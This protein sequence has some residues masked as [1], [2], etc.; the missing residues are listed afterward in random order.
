MP[1]GGC[2]HLSEAWQEIHSEKCHNPNSSWI[3]RVPHFLFDYDQPRCLE[4]ED[5][6]ESPRNDCYIKRS[7]WDLFGNL[8]QYLLDIFI[9]TERLKASFSG[10]DLQADSSPSD[11]NEDFWFP[12]PLSSLFL[13][14]AATAF[15]STCPRSGAFWGKRPSRAGVRASDSLWTLTPAWREARAGETWLVQTWARGTWASARPLLAL[16]VPVA[17]LSPAFLTL[18]SALPFCDPT[19]SSLP[20]YVCHC[21][22]YCQKPASLDLTSGFRSETATVITGTPDPSPPSL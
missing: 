15:P 11:R 18:V 19:S 1:V 12:V 16:L 6:D 13:L 21:W 4:L 9:A 7:A 20:F 3:C 2:R 8:A 22:F 14:D 17:A 5:L 10:I